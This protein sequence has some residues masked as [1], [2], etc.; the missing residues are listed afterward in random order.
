MHGISSLWHSYFRKIAVWIVAFIFCFSGCHSLVCSQWLKYLFW[1]GIN[2]PF[3]S[4]I[5]H[6]PEEAGKKGSK[7][8]KKQFKA[9]ENLFKNIYRK[10]HIFKYWWGNIWPWELR[11]CLC[12]VPCVPSRAQTMW[13]SKIY[14]TKAEEI[15]NLRKKWIKDLKGQFGNALAGN[16][17]LG[18][19]W[20]R[21]L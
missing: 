17:C 15:A 19:S 16:W 6:I 18:S 2:T 3:S 5:Q 10:V 14:V 9:A 7:P 4:Q 11:G 12:F 8:Q 13:R 1:E 21:S 20:P